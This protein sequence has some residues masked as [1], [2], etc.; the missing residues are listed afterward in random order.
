LAS[1]GGHVAVARLLV[2]AGADTSAADGNG[3]TPL[4]EAGHEAMARL[5]VEAGADASAADG[6]GWTPLDWASY[7]GRE[8][9]ARLLRNQRATENQLTT[10]TTPPSTL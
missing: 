10:T 6:K 5:L 9:M 4:H 1:K 7:R 3:R 2:E 8:A